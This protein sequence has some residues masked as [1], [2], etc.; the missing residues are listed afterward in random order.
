[1]TVGAQVNGVDGKRAPTA[2]GAPKSRQQPWQ[3]STRA[4]FGFDPWR[5]GFELAVERRGHLDGCQD[6]NQDG[7]VRWATLTGPAGTPVVRHVEHV[8]RA[9]TTAYIIHASDAGVD[10]PH[11]LV[12]HVDESVIVRANRVPEGELVMVEL[13]DGLVS[14]AGVWAEPVGRRPTLHVSTL[15]VHTGTLGPLHVDV[16]IEDFK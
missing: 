11:P 14:V 9:R 3:P 2:P 12:R 6:G 1:M 7:S 10:V 15:T 4:S 16:R 8:A 5:G 13:C